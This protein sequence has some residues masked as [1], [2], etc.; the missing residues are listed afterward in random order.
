M[1]KYKHKANS[2]GVGI[3]KHLPE[4]EKRGTLKREYISPCPSGYF[5]K[6]K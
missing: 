6:S 5:Y 3:V 2:F 4:R 1:D